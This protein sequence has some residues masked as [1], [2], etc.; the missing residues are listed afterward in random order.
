MKVSTSLCGMSMRHGIGVSD[1]R[2]LSKFSILI[3]FMDCGGSPDCLM[4]VKNARSRGLHMSVILMI[5]FS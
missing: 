4:T 5:S 3:C 2:I 1:S